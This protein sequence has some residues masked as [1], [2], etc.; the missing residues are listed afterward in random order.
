[1]G[2]NLPLFTV[3]ISTYNRK[4]VLPR[5]ISSV[6]GQTCGDFELIV[7]D[8]GS[9]D[10]TESA[11]SDIKDPRIKYIRNPEPTSSCDGPRNMGI[12]MA[13]GSYIAFLDD[14]DIWYPQRLEKVKEAFDSDPGVSAICHN[15]NRNYKGKVDKVLEYGPWSEDLHERLLYDGNC[16]SSC[17]T[18]VRAE[19]LRALNG[20]DTRREYAAAGDYEFWIR[21]TASGAKVGFIKEPLGEFGFTG[22]NWSLRDAAFQSR[23]AAIV[24]DHILMQ[25]KKNIYGV[26][27]RGAARLSKL[28]A[29]AARSFFRAGRPL[30]AL[31]YSLKALF[32]VLIRPNLVIRMLSRGKER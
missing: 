4:H 15:E 20:F 14:D 19:V 25:E 28:Y 8:N 9:T 3:V 5:A 17:G 13:K 30:P 2:D 18:T 1:M 12:E 23:V 24:R 31:A 22:V 26:S 29:I 6:L 10:G 32:L 7:I 16:M 27:E 21:M 11:V